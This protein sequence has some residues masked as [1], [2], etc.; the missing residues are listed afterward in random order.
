MAPRVAKEQPMCSK[1]AAALIAAFAV[2]TTALRAAEVP[3]TA[4]KVITADYQ[5]GCVAAMNPTNG[6]LDAAFAFLSPGFV[7]I[8]VKG[9][10]HSRD[11]VVAMGKQNLTQLKTTACEPFTESSVLNIDGTVTVV[12]DLHLMGEVLTPNGN[13]Q[14]EVTA[15]AQDTWQQINGTWMQT[16]SQELRNQV[17]M[18]G[19]VVQDEGQ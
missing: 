4:Q 12:E 19:N 18:D 14:L 16:Q 5:L 3:Q 6:N 15:K 17:K 8:G 13:H 2:T 10:K 1:F 9:E 7:D 11:E